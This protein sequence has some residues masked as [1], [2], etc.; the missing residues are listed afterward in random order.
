[1]K[2]A[3]KEIHSVDFRLA[4][5]CRWQTEWSRQLLPILLTVPGSNLSTGRPEAMRVERGTPPDTIG[6][7][8][9]ASQV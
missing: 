2:R 1:M 5:D 8:K 7:L 6:E 4:G 3:F 9:I